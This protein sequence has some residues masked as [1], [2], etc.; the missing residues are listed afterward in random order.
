MKKL[1]TILIIICA[2]LSI[3]ESFSQEEFYIGSWLTAYDLMYEK[4]YGHSINNSD[5][6]IWPIDSILIDGYKTSRVNVL[7]D[8]GVNFIWMQSPF[9]W[10]LS[11]VETNKKIFSLFNNHGINVI[12]DI[13]YW[14]KPTL[15]NGEYIN[16]IGV[17]DFN[18]EPDATND[19]SNN[20]GR[21]NYRAILSKLEDNPSVFGYV[22][23]GELAYRSGHF[24][25][26]TGTRVDYDKRAEL[27]QTSEISPAMLI[28]AIDSV[29]ILS[30]KKI[31]L[32]VGTHNSVINDNT[33]DFR[34]WAKFIDGDT[35]HCTV[36]RHYIFIEDTLDVDPQDHFQNPEYYPDI[37]IEGSYFRLTLKNDTA[38]NS[39]FYYPMNCFK[40]HYSNL[41]RRG[42]GQNGYPLNEGS[43]ISCPIMDADYDTSCIDSA[44]YGDN[45][46]YL[47]KFKN[48]DYFRA[49]GIDVIS[50]FSSYQSY[51]ELDTSQQY[52]GAYIRDMGNWNSTNFVDNANYFWF[53]AYNSI[54]HGAV[55]I[56]PYIE[57][58]KLYYN[59]CQD[60]LSLIDIA[61]ITIDEF[62]Y[63]VYNENPLFFTSHNIEQS[64]IK[65]S[66]NENYVSGDTIR[67]SDNH[68][69]YYRRLIVQALYK[70][71]F[72]TK[73]EFEQSNLND[74]LW[75]DGRKDRFDFNYWPETF[76][77][78]I[79][80]LYNEISLLKR[81]GFLDK[82]SVIARKLDY[83]DPKC[84]VPDASIYIDTLDS[85]VSGIP[86]KYLTAIGS[87]YVSQESSA[88]YSGPLN[89]IEE[90]SNENYGLRYV[91]L[92]NCNRS[93]EEYVLIISNPLNLPI[94]NVP[95]NVSHFQAL[96]DMDVAQV[97]F[98]TNLSATNIGFSLNE[99]YKKQ[100]KLSF[101]WSEASLDEIPS[102]NLNIDASG[103]FKVNFGPLDVQIIRF[104]KTNC[105][106]SPVRKVWSDL[107]SGR[108]GGHAL[109]QNDKPLIIGDF[110]GDETEEILLIRY[111]A[112]N[113]SWA[114]TQL[115]IEGNFTNAF[116][117]SGNGWI[118]RQNEG[119]KIGSDDVYL[120]GNYINNTS[121]DEVLC[122]QDP[123]TSVSN[124][125]VAMI[126]FK[127]DVADWDYWFWSNPSDRTKIGSWT[128]S[129][130]SKYFS[131]NFDSDN[132]DEVLFV[133]YSN[134][135]ITEL[136][137]QKYNHSTNSWTVLMSNSN[138]NFYKNSKITV[139]NF[140]S[141]D[142]KYEIFITNG[143]NAK[144]VK[145]QGNNLVEI[146]NNNTHL[147]S[148]GPDVKPSW[149]LSPSDII[150]SDKFYNGINNSDNL[151]L[152]RDPSN[153]SENSPSAIILYFNHYTNKWY[154]TWSNNNC[155]ENLICDWEVF[156]DVYTKIEYY[157]IRISSTTAS[158]ESEE[159]TSI[160]H[161]LA[162]RGIKPVSHTCMPNNMN[163]KMYSFAL[164]NESRL[165]S[166]TTNNSV[167][168]EDNNSSFIVKPNPTKN[169]IDIYST[170][171]VLINGIEVWD[172]YGKKLIE[173]K[174]SPRHNCYLDLNNLT[175][176][177]YIIKILSGDNSYFKQIVKE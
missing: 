91:L 125:A 176:G 151:F 108:I 175:S 119:W 137:I 135:Y 120:A 31:V 130:N 71:I 168:P 12:G 25:N 103:E 16:T 45:R 68:M 21:P 122:I 1:V 76:Q 167:D 121:G 169:S 41:F 98:T 44:I 127:D 10:L 101:D 24:Y 70:L 49:K 39:N 149:Y 104:K 152:I 51:F 153:N 95:L 90:F 114:T 54:I 92:S 22:L 36:D 86:E 107:N 138:P 173:N 172:T 6:E 132:L 96:H 118:N 174:E 113:T 32:Q 80:P 89:F 15:V 42:I 75:T 144:L 166:N 150:I 61:G 28:S 4:Y 78:H 93:D 72:S 8:F 53:N 161:L 156:S 26:I 64:E 48:I 99:N 84:L 3:K 140:I 160:V 37:A 73:G 158:E 110:Y 34:G 7:K 105:C 134:N 155:T 148:M 106:V 14:F 60:M 20:L 52:V 77:T 111:D 117:N 82:K 66:C 35:I 83:K 17:V 143:Y 18:G 19:S 38:P 165:K 33:D 85:N 79:S 67:I 124:R 29:K 154:S 159:S 56:L 11:G 146:W 100:R 136:M 97:L 55:G 116:N 58:S 164:N 139:G 133:R 23:G 162:L 88:W 177:V 94:L 62:R 102:V 27:C 112:T 142:G 74:T 43:D 163:S 147:Q 131:G 115:F 170:D 129:A 65:M 30:D 81:M 87:F 57:Y 69:D 46:H 5:Y 145:V 126:G 109:N 9:P 2:S 171:G 40:Y 50:E 128:L 59:P 63:R 47:S 157:P 13:D 123:Q 141:S